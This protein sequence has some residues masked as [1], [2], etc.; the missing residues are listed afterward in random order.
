MKGLTTGLLLVGLCAGSTTAFAWSSNTS[1]GD[2]F[3]LLE[4]S[5]KWVQGNTTMYLQTKNGDKVKIL[6]PKG[7]MHKLKGTRHGDSFKLME[8]Q[9]T[10]EKNKY[11]YTN[12]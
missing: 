5:G 2:K 9:G 10:L 6:V 3:L 1:G 12:H 4:G 7:E 8:R 11:P